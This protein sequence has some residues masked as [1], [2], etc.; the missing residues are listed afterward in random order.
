MKPTVQLAPNVI[1]VY[2]EGRIDIHASLVFEELFN[3]AIEEYPGCHLLVD[4]SDIEYI[5]S[6]GLRVFV[7]TKHKLRAAHLE[8]KLCNPNSI[9]RKI[10]ELTEISSILEVYDSTDEALR[11]F[12]SVTGT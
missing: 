2:P 3:I 7:K 12:Q 9:C 11:S 8:M 4:M 10:M 6:S 5:S 1:A